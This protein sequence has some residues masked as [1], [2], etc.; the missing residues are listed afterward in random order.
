MP[1]DSYNALV[2]VSDRSDGAGAVGAVTISAVVRVAVLVVSV[3]PVDVV[4]DSVVV[5]V[6]TVAGDFSSVGP[7]VGLEVGM[8]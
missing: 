4:H 6:F 2:V 1:I 5:V 8:V 7:E 3:E